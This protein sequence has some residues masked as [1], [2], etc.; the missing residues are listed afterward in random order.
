MRELNETARVSTVGSSLAVA[1]PRPP[2]APTLAHAIV[3]AGALHTIAWN[4]VLIDVLVVPVP[5]LV[6]TVGIAFVA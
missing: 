6:S 1:L 4:A 3:V 5:T 2:S